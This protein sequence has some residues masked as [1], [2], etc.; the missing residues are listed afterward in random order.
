[1]KSKTRKTRKAR[2][3]NPNKMRRLFD[4]CVVDVVYTVV[5]MNALWMCVNKMD[6]SKP[7]R[8]IEFLHQR[9]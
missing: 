1:M 3:R 9:K 4:K 7:L 5:E 8:N 2:K 6:K